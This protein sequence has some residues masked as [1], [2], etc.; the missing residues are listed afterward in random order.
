M[1]RRGAASGEK[2]MRGARLVMVGVLL[3]GLQAS[4]KAE[5]RTLSCLCTFNCL[6]ILFPF[7]VL[8]CVFKGFHCWRERERDIERET[9][10]ST[11]L[12]F[13][14]MQLFLCKIPTQPTLPSLASLL[15][16]GVWLHDTL[17]GDNRKQ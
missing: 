10:Q 1:R 17:R 7:V 4:K 13:S 12:F 6:P 11:I 14:I 3:V 8:F 16:H 2:A 15:C 9:S 5:E